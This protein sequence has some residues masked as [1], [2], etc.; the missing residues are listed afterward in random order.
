MR[1]SAAAREFSRKHKSRSTRRSKRQDEPPRKRQK[2]RQPRKELR[3]PRRRR[4]R[5]Y[6]LTSVLPYIEIR[7]A[8]SVEGAFTFLY[9]KLV[10]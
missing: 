5:S 7:N 4:A 10:S 1:P 8:P 2:K 6:S 9:A 3:P